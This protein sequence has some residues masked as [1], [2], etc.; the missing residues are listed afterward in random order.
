MK[1]FELSFRESS[2]KLPRLSGSIFGEGVLFSWAGSSKGLM[3]VNSV[4]SGT[5]E[6]LRFA[7]PTY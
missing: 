7:M 1:D 3:K 2:H 5:R 4:D 6:Q